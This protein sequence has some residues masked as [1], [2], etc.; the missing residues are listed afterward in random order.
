MIEITNVSKSYNGS[1]YA[2]KDLSLS[3]PSGEIFGFLGPNGAGKST[4]IKMITGIHGVDKGTITING[5]DIMKNPME[6]KKTFG[7]VPDSPDMFLRLK[8]IEYL[9]FMADMYEVPK[10]V[11]QERIESL[12]KKFDLY[13]ALSDQIQSYS[14]G[15]RQKIVI[16]GVLVHEPDIWILDEPLTGLD[17][18]SAYIL[19]EMMREHA[20]KGKIVFFSTHVLEVAEKICDRVA[21]IN[22][23]NLQF[24]GNLDEM[25]DHFKSNESLEKMFLE[26][27]GNE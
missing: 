15:M 17:P 9:N 19:K 13:N 23:G 5:I 4:T 8:G 11:R 24:K 27:T 21:I 18:K 6:A 10:E 3:V 12:A 20:D 22:K 2:V 16:I 1:T 14:H 26:M 25:R 7:Y